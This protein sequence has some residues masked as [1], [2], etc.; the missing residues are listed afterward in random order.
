MVWRLGSP[1]LLIL[2]LRRSYISALS[3]LLLVILLGIAKL[4]YYLLEAYAILILCIVVD[5]LF[6][7][8]F[9]QWV[10]VTYFRQIFI[11][12]ILD[13]VCYFVYRSPVDI[14]I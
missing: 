2:I 9:C 1:D 8:W 5:T 11:L 7:F 12:D 10:A 13:H 14:F 3:E 6:F 4:Y